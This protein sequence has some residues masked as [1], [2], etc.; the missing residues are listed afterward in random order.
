M[1]LDFY[2]TCFMSSSMFCVRRTI[3]AGAGELQKNVSISFNANQS[4]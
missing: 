4:S 3:E 2:I 1:N